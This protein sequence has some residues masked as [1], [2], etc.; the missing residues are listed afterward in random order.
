MQLVVEQPVQLGAEVRIQWSNKEIPGKVRY[1]QRCCGEYRLGVALASPSDSLLMGLLARETATPR[2][3]DEE[4]GISAG[5]LHQEIRDMSAALQAATRSSEIKSKLLAS[6]SHE[7]RTPL[8]GIIGFSELLQDAKAGPVTADQKEY[9]ADILSCSRHLL[10]LIN[11][12]LDL[13][14]IESGKMDFQYEPV[15]LRALSN[16]VMEG[17]K[18]LAA[19]KHI[20]VRIDCDPRVAVVKADP[21]RLRQV[22]FNFLSNALKFTPDGGS[23]AVRVRPECPSCYRVTVEDSG[24]GI[25][26][27]DISRLFKEFGQ[28]GA[29]RASGLGTGLGLAITRQI[30]ERQGGRV[31]VES[32][33]GVGSSFWAV[34]PVNPTA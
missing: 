12:V 23:V 25:R 14:K 33:P 15:E 29:A 20:K 11:Q 31:G 30:V 13:T 27:E 24:V 18:G 4:V 19:S 8:N 5:L 7:F 6:V 32:T 22:L 21:A 9:L 28:V 16:E 10:T 34:L 3:I 17:V 1:Q 26:A 2:K